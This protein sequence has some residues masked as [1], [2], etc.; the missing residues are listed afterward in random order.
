MKKAFV[1]YLG[2]IDD[3]WIRASEVPIIVNLV[4]VEGLPFA[5]HQVCCHVEPE[6]V[7]TFH[8]MVSDHGLFQV[9]RNDA[10]SSYEFGAPQEVV[11]QGPCDCVLGD[12]VFWRDADTKDAVSAYV[13]GVVEIS[14]AKSP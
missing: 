8:P 11:R 9:L 10:F 13:D 2:Y 5:N 12:R 3:A 14:I 4:P 6:V 1:T 7:G